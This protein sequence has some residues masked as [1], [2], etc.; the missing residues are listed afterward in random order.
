MSSSATSPSIYNP[1]EVIIAVFHYPLLLSNRGLKH[2]ERLDRI[3][4]NN[5][6][7]NPFSVNNEVRLLLA[8]KKFWR[9]RWEVATPSLTRHR[10]NLDINTHVMS[11]GTRSRSRCADHINAEVE[12]RR[13]VKCFM[14]SVSRVAKYSAHLELFQG[15]TNIRMFLHSG[16]LYLASCKFNRLRNYRHLHSLVF[17]H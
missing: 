7:T 8:S 12:R 6:K 4:D 2:R 13:L 3:C 11:H 5:A 9:L 17:W 15:V 10:R 1:N 14:Y 16:R